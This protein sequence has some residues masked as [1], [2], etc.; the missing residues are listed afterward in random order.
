[1]EL[2]HLAVLGFCVQEDRPDPF[3]ADSRFCRLVED[4]P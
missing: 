2:H 4:Q 3:P 1:L